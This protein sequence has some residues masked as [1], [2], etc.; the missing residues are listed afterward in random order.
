MHKNQLNETNYPITG[1]KPGEC[2]IDDE[3]EDTMFDCR[4]DQ[5]CPGQKKCCDQSCTV[6]NLDGLVCIYQGIILQSG[7]FYYEQCN[8][9]S[10]NAGVLECS[11]LCPV[12]KA[13]SCPVP[14]V[15]ALHVDC[16][17]TCQQDKDCNGIEKCCGCDS[18]CVK[19]LE[20][21]SSSDCF[22]RNE[23]HSDSE[24]FKSD[25]YRCQCLNGSIVCRAPICPPVPCPNPV[26]PENECCPICLDDSKPGECPATETN[27]SLSTN[28]SSPC[29]DDV[30]CPDDKKCCLS[31]DCGL[32]CK[33]PS[34][35]RSGMCPFLL[36]QSSTS[37]VHECQIDD[38]CDE[39]QK[40]C[41]NTCDAKVCL[42]AIP[43]DSVV[44]GD[45]PCL[46]GG[47]C[48]QINDTFYQCKCQSGFYGGH[49]ENRD[50]SCHPNPCKNGGK[51][52]FQEESGLS[53]CDCTEGFDGARCNLESSLCDEITC[54]NGGICKLSLSTPVCSC[55]NGYTGTY[56]EEPAMNCSSIVCE[57]GG[58][59]IDSAGFLSS[60][61]SILTPLWDCQCPGGFVGDFCEIQDE[62]CDDNKCQNGGTCYK[63]TGRPIATYCVCADGFTGPTCQQLEVCQSQPCLNGGT[64][65]ILFLS[66]KCKC[67]ERYSGVNCEIESHQNCSTVICQN[68]GTCIQDESSKGWQCT[69]PRNF[70]G[71]FC[72][73]YDPCIAGQPC[74]NGGS[75]QP[76]I[77]G[78]I[79]CA[80]PAGTSGNRCENS[81]TDACFFSPC[82]NGGSCSE[83]KGFPDCSCTDGHTGRFCEITVNDT[84]QNGTKP[85]SCLFDPCHV[86]SCPAHPDARCKSNYCGG[87]NAEFYDDVGNR[88]DCRECSSGE[89]V[90]C[91]IHPCDL[92]TCVNTP[93]AYCDISYCHTSCEPVF[94]ISDDELA[95]CDS[96]SE[97]RSCPVDPCEVCTTIP[98]GAECRVD[99]CNSCAAEIYNANGNKIGVCPDTSAE[100]LPGLPYVPC[101]HDPC[102][103]VVCPGHPDA[104]CTP[105]YCGGCTP[106][107]VDPVSGVRLECDA[108]PDNEPL[109]RCA[110]DPCVSATC[111]AYPG[112]LCRINNCGSCSAEFISDTGK[113]LDCTDYCKDNN[114]RLG[115]KCTPFDG[116]YYCECPSFRR[117]EFCEEN[118]CKHEGAEYEL[119]EKMDSDE[120]NKCKCR[121]NGIW[122][123]TEYRCDF[124]CVD[125]DQTYYSG[126]VRDDKDGCNTC[127]CNEQGGWDC[128]KEACD[129]TLVEV[130]FS[131]DLNFADIEDK[132]QDFKESL[133]LDLATEFSI[134]VTALKDFQISPGSVIVEF[135]LVSGDLTA[136]DVNNA[137]ADI[138]TQLQSGD[139]IFTYDGQDISV[140]PDSVTVST[141]LKDTD[142]TNEALIIGVCVAVAVLIVIIVIIIIVIYKRKESER[143]QYVSTVTTISVT[144]KRNTFTN[145]SFESETTK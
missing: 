57:N 10:C 8:S 50:P 127:I 35:G 32:T 70:R 101:L 86:A 138:Q 47:V 92:T 142:D 79:K 118:F 114:C 97:P 121:K 140:I 122:E 85:V 74:E 36:F 132:L 38:H 108:C 62:F 144:K 63:I 105:D 9:C 48:S 66:Y 134:P 100:C 84:C 17:A 112:A 120:C 95:N 22:F 6:P 34:K 116:G 89:K 143:K 137:A 58:E 28:C 29:Q 98:D 103:N 14:S 136:D 2:P 72:E 44:C 117:G 55:I 46:N 26:M 16:I 12:E 39:G 77:D 115:L 11:R 40:C 24:K 80:C 3:D 102:L 133:R 56:C 13:G 90:R 130:K 61:A 106:K 23:W 113:V 27:S 123:C 31:D 109:Y 91:V 82:L 88:V 135:K 54:L 68:S 107:F 33:A 96:C 129:V 67:Q 20:A 93:R 15:E 19:P 128:T 53:S 69:C 81:V 145:T 51:C 124:T 59:C 83:F 71:E 4:T 52:V 7:E 37:C 99:K 125:R 139:Y 131:F 94:L 30:S 1:E 104:A 64:C 5:D 49:C 141:P 126:D 111:S 21:N 75:C 65:L 41:L 73:E 45:Q 78:G 110:S 76:A 25:C 43:E 18:G 87:C 60:S 42:D 119:G